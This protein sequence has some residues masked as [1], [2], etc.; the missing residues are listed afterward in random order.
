MVFEK[1]TYLKHALGILLVLMALT[2]ILQN[3][4]L[5]IG[6][7]G[8]CISVFVLCFPIK[9]K[10]YFSESMFFIL[11]LLMTSVLNL[12]FTQ[13]NFGGSITFLGNLLL[14]FIYIQHDDK[15]LTFWVV[16]GYITTIGFISYHLF[17][18]GTHENFIY[19]GLSRNHAGF[20]VVFWTIFLHFHL[21]VNYNY[22]PLLPP[23]IALI[24]SYFLIGRTS[25]GVSAFLLIIVFFYKFKTNRKILFF[26]S[27]VLLAVFYNLF[28]RFSDN[29]FT[30]TNL[31]SGLDTPRWELWDIYWKHLNFNNILTGIDVTKLP[32]YDLYSGNPHNSFIKFHSRT[33]L[34]SF[35][36]M[37]LF[38][39]SCFKYLSQ[40]EV[41]VF[42]LLF[43]LTL[44]ATF[45]GDMFVGNFDFIFLIVTFYW[46]KQ[47]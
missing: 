4:T 9:R 11:F 39:L 29:L 3:K 20:A 41:Y 30:E 21:K 13:N 28:I 14:T 47:D 37:L 18:L 2:D 10:K 22:L 15:S 45:D 12:Y 35:A 46:I 31:D 23:S 24:L 7:A 40:K 6:T 25:L 27:V 38:I 26:S 34:G 43:L 44:R 16:L 36:F 19:P 42:C 33:G 1:D 5:L 17:I 8:L 32:V